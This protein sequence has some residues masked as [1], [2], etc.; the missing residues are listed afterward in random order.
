MSESKVRKQVRDSK[1]ILIKCGT[2]IVTNE[3]DAVSGNLGYTSADVFSDNDSL[4]ALCGKAFEVD[5]VLLLT[6]V[7]G[8][9]DRPPKSPG[10]QLLPFYFDY[11]EK[12]GMK[13]NKSSEI[14]FGDKSTCGRGGMEA[15]IAAALSAVSHGS[16]EEKVRANRAREEAR[17]LGRMEYG[18]RRGVLECIARKLV[19]E[20]SVEM[21][22]EANRKDLE[23][24]MEVKTDEHLIKRLKLTRDKLQ[25]L[26]SGI[27]QIAAEDDPLGVVKSKLEVAEGLVL[28]EQTVPIGVL[29][30][31][32]ESRPDSFPQI[33]ALSIA[34]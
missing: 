27:L 15:K 20:N 32:F 1:R 7:R 10:A 18:E 19:E 13:R 2:S 4:A 33:A 3:N 31:I 9:Y 17:K 25:T 12:E 24:A 29:M 22:L 28:T 11:I 34:R 21:I 16:K 14:L 23:E 30:I 26:S 5:T 6:D 8:V